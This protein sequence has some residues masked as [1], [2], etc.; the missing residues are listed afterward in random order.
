MAAYLR[1]ACVYLNNDRVFLIS[2]SIKR[3]QLSESATVSHS[4]I[5]TCIR[6]IFI[7]TRTLFLSKLK[8]QAKTKFRLNHLYHNER[9]ALL[10][11]LERINSQISNFIL[12]SL[13]HTFLFGNPCFN[14]ET[15]T[16]IL[17]AT[18]DYILS[19]HRFDKPL[20]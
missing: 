15:N 12:H 2:Y 19:T 7:R 3:T 4:Y 13:T 11:S 10:K 20:F 8:A 5:L 6:K 9:R 14:D 17:D 16:Q 18:I 1:Q